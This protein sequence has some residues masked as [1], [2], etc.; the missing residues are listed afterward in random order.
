[1]IEREIKGD[2]GLTKL[3]I[4]IE[5]DEASVLFRVDQGGAIAT[6]LDTFKTEDLIE[7]GQTL[8]LN[9]RAD[10]ASQLKSDAMID[11]KL[12]RGDFNDL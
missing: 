5:G 12:R 1:M 2:S 8:T 3:K 11:A 10:F 7:L 4:Q 9:E 6:F